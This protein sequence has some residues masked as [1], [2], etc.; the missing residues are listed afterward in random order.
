MLTE[1]VRS[2]REK[3]VPSD[4]LDLVRDFDTY[5]EIVPAY[6]EVLRDEVYRIRY[7]VYAEELGWENT[8]QF[9][10]DREQ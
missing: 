6:T 4:P 2:T 3:M 10:A 5:F 7:Q 8:E 1:A 9:P